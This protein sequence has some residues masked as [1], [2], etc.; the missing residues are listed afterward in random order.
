L[1]SKK[2]TKRQKEIAGRLLLLRERLYGNASE[3]ARSIKLTPQAWYNYETGRRAL[4]VEIAAIVVEEHGV[5]FNWLYGGDTSTLKP[6]IKRLLLANDW[7]QP[8]LEARAI[9]PRRKGARRAAPKAA[10][11]QER[12]GSR[13]NQAR[14]S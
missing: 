1:S 7:A 14:A 13:G 5:D 6:E 9:K 3:M 8:H 2:I 12:N 4:G 10:T 11:K